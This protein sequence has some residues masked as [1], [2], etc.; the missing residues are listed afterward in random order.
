MVNII[1]LVIWEKRVVFFSVFF[2]IEKQRQRQREEVGRDE[3]GKER[4][5]QEKTI[6]RFLLSG[7]WA[8]EVIQL[9]WEGSVQAMDDDHWIRLEKHLGERAAKL[10]TLSGW[11]GCRD[12]QKKKKKDKGLKIILKRSKLAAGSDFECSW[13]CWFWGDCWLYKSGGKLEIAV[14]SSE[15]PVEDTDLGVAR[16]MRL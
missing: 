16:S 10:C 6:I 3:G 8:G 4:R 15:S 13:N 9:G 11:W 7:H 12:Q 2:Q 14:L 5:M 1:I